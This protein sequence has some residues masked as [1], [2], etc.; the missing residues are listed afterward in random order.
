MPSTSFSDQIS[1]DDENK[2]LEVQVIWQPPFTC[3]GCSCDSHSHRFARSPS[4][5][6]SFLGILFIGYTSL[7]LLRPACNVPGCQRRKVQGFS[8]SWYFPK[9]FVK[10]MIAFTYV[11]KPSSGLQ[12]P[13]KV[14]RIVDNGAQFFAMTHRGD[15]EGL[16]EL[17]EKKA[18]ISSERR[19]SRWL[20]G[21]SCQ[22][23]A[24]LG[25][26]GR[27]YETNRSGVRSSPYLFQTPQEIAWKK[28]L[29]RQ[30]S[31]GVIKQLREAFPLGDMVEYGFTR[32][33]KVIL[34]LEHC[35]LERV[36]KEQPCAIDAQDMDMQT[37]LMW[38][39]IGRNIE[40]VRT[41][42]RYGADTNHRSKNGTQPLNMAA[43][44]GDVECIESLIGKG[45]KINRTY[46]GI[47]CV[48]LACSY[49]DNV[50]LLEKLL[51]L[52]PD[53][54]YKDDFG[55]SYMAMTAW[56]NR[57]KC[58]KLLLERGADREAVDI[59]GATPLLRAVQPSQ[60]QGLV[61]LSRLKVARWSTALK[62]DASQAARLRSRKETAAEKLS[63]VERWKSTLL[64]ECEEYV[65]RAVP[66]GLR[67]ILGPELDRDLHIVEEG[68]M[69]KAIDCVKELLAEAFREFR[70][71]E[72]KT[73][74][75]SQPSPVPISPLQVF[76]TATSKAQEGVV[77]RDAVEEK[78]VLMACQPQTTEFGNGVDLSHIDFIS[79]SNAE[80][81]F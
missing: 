53:L 30:A 12:V 34:G 77:D 10:R 49:H 22:S 28:I 24:P 79:T 44:S 51:A 48:H 59:F 63:K 13:L 43:R 66:P 17:F 65:L 39:C 25:R 19:S 27:F 69:R 80:D 58:T 31:R 68:L 70:E 50:Q 37:P 29:E 21:P 20:Y 45:A 6:E 56:K 4:A 41:L 64:T 74:S 75:Q 71:I 18:G 33:H 62:F 8:L 78:Q 40:A 60:V 15:V 7:P 55:R 67:Q 14:S 16:K 1:A 61:R 26:R 32:V 76:P 42:L 38:A 46:F 54:N 81:H 23:P 35:G 9:W 5:V 11:M 72:Q 47:D 36:I 52:G 3:N 73:G 57:H 2:G